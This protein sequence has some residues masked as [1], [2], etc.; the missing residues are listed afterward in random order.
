MIIEFRTTRDD[1]LV[2]LAAKGWHYNRGL[3]T[4]TTRAITPR[5]AMIE[6][7]ETTHLD[8]WRDDDFHFRAYNPG[9]G[10]TLMYCSRQRMWVYCLRIGLDTPAAP[11]IY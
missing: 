10:T 3:G 2:L 6:W 1:I 5:D 4:A 7:R 8:P 11:P 9:T